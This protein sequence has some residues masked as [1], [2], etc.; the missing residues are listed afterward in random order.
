M[1]SPPVSLSVLSYVAALLE[2][3]MDAVMQIY[4]IK[5]CLHAGG[6]SKAILCTHLSRLWEQKVEGPPRLMLYF[7]MHQIAMRPNLNTL[8]AP[9]RSCTR[10]CPATFFF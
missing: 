6:V 5:A 8:I 3:F 1:R 10:P 7:W 9:L 4:L 2:K